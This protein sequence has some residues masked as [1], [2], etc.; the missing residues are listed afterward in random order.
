MNDP[1][2]FV[3]T[4]ISVI[5]VLYVAYEKYKSAQTN[6]INATGS[7]N[8]SLSRA[9]QTLLSESQEE[10]TRLRTQVNE[11]EIEVAR[12]RNIEWQVER[13]KSEVLRLG[14]E[15]AALKRDKSDKRR[16]QPAPDNHDNAATL[17]LIDQS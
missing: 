9:A 2:S 3:T 14:D 4:I 11:L 8:E 12:L 10:I 13:L 6:H 5:T 16:K 17:P 1:L 15:N 7:F